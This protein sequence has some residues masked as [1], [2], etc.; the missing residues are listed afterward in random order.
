M[1]QRT[2]RVRVF[3][4]VHILNRISPLQATWTSNL[5]KPNKG[6]KY[7]CHVISRGDGIYCIFP[8]TILTM[9]GHKGFGGSSNAHPHPNING[10][11]KTNGMYILPVGVSCR[12]HWDLTLELGLR[13]G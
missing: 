13:L 7:T 3:V 10:P 1:I 6:L 8:M 4:Y 5:A 9:T 12:L 11:G 2:V